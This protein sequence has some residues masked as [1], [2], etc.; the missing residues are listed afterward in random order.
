[1]AAA[2]LLFDRKDDLFIITLAAASMVGLLETVEVEEGQP[3]TLSCVAPPMEHGPLQW[4]APSGFTIFL[5][6]HPGKWEKHQLP[7]V[8]PPGVFG[9]TWGS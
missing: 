6:Q 3:V 1:M 9:Q 7:P 5:N 4:V 2:K 8:L